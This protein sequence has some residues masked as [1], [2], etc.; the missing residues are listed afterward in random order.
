MTTSTGRVQRGE[1]TRTLWSLRSA[2]ARVGVFSL[3]VNLLMLAPT[4]YMLQVYDRVLASRSELT[5]LALSLITLVLLA[6]LAASEAVRSRVLVRA[7]LRFD[8][9]LSSRV[10]RASFA[11]VLGPPAAAPSRAFGDLIELRQFLTGQGIFALCDAPWSPLYIGVLFLLHPWLGVLAIG[12][13]LIQAALAWLGHRRTVAP[14]AAASATQAEAMAYLQSKLRHSEVIESMGM[15]GNLRQRW[16]RRHQ[17]HLARQD[18]ALGLT[19][20]VTA[21]SKF[22][23]YAQQ[24]LALGGGAL[25]VIDGQLSPGA[26][27]AANVLMTRALAPID[28][29]VSAW[30]GFV[31]ARDAFVRLGTLLD[32]HPERHRVAATAIPSGAV[33]VSDVVA[34][35]PGRAAPLLDGVSLSVPAGTVTVVLGPSGSGKSTLAR[36]LVGLWPCQSGRM[37]LDGRP[38]DQWSRTELGPHIGYLPQDVELFEGSIAENIARFG[39]VDAVRVIEAA[40]A[41]GLH[42]TILRFPKGYDT[43]VGAEGGVL[44]GGQRQRIGLARALHGDPALVVLDEPNANLDDAGEAALLAAVRGCRE[45][46]RTV[47]L[48][49]HRPGIVEVADRLL[50]LREG[51]VQ[52]EGP[53]DAVIAALKSAEPAVLR[54]EPLQPEPVSS[55]S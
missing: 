7:G 6:V 13:V 37:L 40:R 20:R 9:R 34:Q 44:S 35:V 1:L 47:F 15:L 4:I 21:F 54:P 36:V 41:A 24:S 53:R 39:A 8:Q 31:G 27:I 43:P 28:Q 46:G 14:L 45:R 10:F 11:A 42:E 22:V 33:S 23:R 30:R 3:V 18:A 5:L 29:L 49:S 51:R 16:A 52:L 19:G 17:D 2:F 48:I 38:I 26:M 55:A 32:A 25:L 50:I 12:F